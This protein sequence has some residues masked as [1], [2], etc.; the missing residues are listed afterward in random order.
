M[1][2]AQPHSCQRWTD[3]EMA[4]LRKHVQAGSYV[5]DMLRDIPTRTAWSIRGKAKEMRQAMRVAPPKANGRPPSGSTTVTH[6]DRIEDVKSEAAIGSRLLLEAIH[7]Y[8]VQ[9]VA[10]RVAA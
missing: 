4:A 5:R 3:V 2:G 8:Y 9:H 7:R 10:G 1:T 6:N